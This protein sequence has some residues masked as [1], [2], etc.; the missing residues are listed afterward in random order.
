[1]SAGGLVA[2]EATVKTALVIL[3]GVSGR[4][5]DMC[6]PEGLRKPWGMVRMKKTRMGQAE[7]RGDFARW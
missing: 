6:L 4:P 1:M 7:Q 2:L 5:R 3:C